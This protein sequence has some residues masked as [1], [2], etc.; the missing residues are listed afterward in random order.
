MCGNIHTMIDSLKKLGLSDVEATIYLQLVKKGEMTAVEISKEVKVHR[1]TIYDNLNMLIN[2]GLVSFFT[3]KNVK[4]FNATNPKI[5]KK[6]EEEK[7]AELNA[8]L[9]SLNSFYSN[10]KKNPSVEILKGHDATKNLLFEMQ[11]TKDEILWMGGG[12]KILEHLDFSREKIITQFQKLKLKIIQPT[13]KE[14]LYK[15]Y[16]SGKK[17]KFIDK[18]Y[19]TGTV[20]FTFDNFVLLGTLVNDEFFI[21]KIENENIAQTYKNYFEIMWNN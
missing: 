18:K 12:F 20:F 4:Y 6:I 21:I 9:P 11:N 7:L 3:T 8:I 10:Q 17:I 15:K 14:S 13:P 5:L 19:S 2:K 1:R 16:F